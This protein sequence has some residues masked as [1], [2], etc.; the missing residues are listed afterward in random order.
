MRLE[1][2]VVVITGGNSG[3]GEATAKLFAKE[4]AAVVI[5]ARR[6]EALQKVE[7][8]IKEMGGKVLSVPTDISSNEACEKLIETAVKEFGKV[9]VLV[10]NAGILDTGLKAVDKFS[11]EDLNNGFS[12]EQTNGVIKY[13]RVKEILPHIIH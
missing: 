7:N 5:S 4:G 11:D 8:E 12:I 10:N 9:D 2:K 6:V 3:V 13:Y 1:N